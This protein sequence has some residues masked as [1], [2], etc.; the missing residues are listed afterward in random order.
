[1][2]M[3]KEILVSLDGSELSEAALPHARALAKA[4]DARISLMSIMEPVEMYS[5]TGV[6]GPVVS[7]SMNVQEEIER[8][9][10][11]LEGVAD[12]LI[13]EGIDA[14][15]EVREGDPAAEICDYAETNGVDII[16][17]STHGRSGLQRW[18]YGSVTDRVLRS[19]KVPVFLV[20]ALAK[21]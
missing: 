16:V 18:V 1:M 10:Q 20:R 19:A 5:Q 9:G 21:T 15:T 2:G 7:V 17:M 13:K 4:F 11:Y 14:R 12:N 6:V 8:I 3:Y